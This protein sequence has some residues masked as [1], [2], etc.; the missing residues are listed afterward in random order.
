MFVIC[1]WK[2]ASLKIIDLW[3]K[4]R[5]VSGNRSSVLC[6]SC[7]QTLLHCLRTCRKLLWAVLL[8]VDFFLLC[9]FVKTPDQMAPWDFI[10]LL[11]TNICLCDLLI[12][13]K[14]SYKSVII[15]GFWTRS[16]VFSILLIYHSFH[17]WLFSLI[18][19]QVSSWV[20]TPW[21]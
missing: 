9:I 3:K 1:C 14:E 13:Y 16:C 8:N 17:T 5:A 11:V 20:E 12:L 19:S 10:Y 15:C 6:T 18:Y 7:S 2:N 21:W 4:Q